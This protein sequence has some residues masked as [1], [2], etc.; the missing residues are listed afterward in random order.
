[1]KFQSIVVGLTSAI[2]M[3][4]SILPASAAWAHGSAAAASPR[5]LCLTA[6]EVNAALGGSFRVMP[7]TSI[8]NMGPGFS[9]LQIVKKAGLVNG[10]R[11][12]LYAPAP[13]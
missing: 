12:H 13:R 8:G 3:V 6:A 9:S 2:L 7:G 1:M 10:V 5:A 4:G 11:H